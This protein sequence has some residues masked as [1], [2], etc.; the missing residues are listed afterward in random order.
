MEIVFER[1]LTD[2][3]EAVAL[4]RVRSLRLKV[5]VTMGFLLFCILGTIVLVSLGLTMTQ[6]SMGMLFG[7]YIVVK[8]LSFTYS[9]WLKR[10]F[11]RHPNFTR[12]VRMRIDEAGLK[13]DSDLWTSDTKWGAYLKHA[14]TKNLFL[15]YLGVRSVEIIPKRA[16]SAGQIDEFRRLIHANFPH[17]LD[18][19]EERG[20]CVENPS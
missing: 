16:F 4:Q 13:S 14:E 2:Y 10:D 11:M 20:A 8:G 3:R 19:S 6:G 18:T 7:S 12:Q 17:S 15:L 9:L 5:A 1:T